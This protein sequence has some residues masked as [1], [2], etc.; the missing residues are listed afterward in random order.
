MFRVRG[1]NKVFSQYNITIIIV[2]L[3]I[4]FS[5]LSIITY[6]YFSDLSAHKKTEIKELTQQVKSINE[7]LVKNTK[8]LLSIQKFA[9]YF[10]KYPDDLVTKTPKLIQDGNHYYVQ[11]R[12]YDVIDHKD[13]VRNNI[14]GIGDIDSLDKSHMAEL[15][16]SN[17]LTPAFVATKQANEEAV[18]FYYVSKKRFVSIY[19]SINRNSW[20]Y[21]DILLAGK[22]TQKILQSGLDKQEVVW[23]SPYLGSAGSG[24]NT[25]LGIGVF[26]KAGMAGI[27]YVDISLARLQKQ[28]SPITKD[29]VGVLVL[30]SQNKVLIHHKSSNE[31][32]G[33]IEPWENVVPQSLSLLTKND[34]NHLSLYQERG[35][36]LVQKQTL[37]INGWSV[38][39]YQSLQDFRQ[40][41]LKHYSV[42]FLILFVGLTV[43]FA[44]IYWITHRTFVKPTKRFISHIEYCAQGDPG[45]IKPTADWLRW[46]Q[47]VENIFGQNRSL[48]QRLTDQNLLLDTRVNEKTQELQEKV[49]QHKRDYALLKSVMN[50]IPE[51][52][53]FNDIDG[54]IVG[55]NDT[56]G[57][58][59]EKSRDE[60]LGLKANEI[61]LNE[62]GTALTKL[63]T[64]KNV[65][66]GL[67][68]VVHTKNSTYDIYCTNIHSDT[69]IEVGT[70]DIIRDVTTQ[71][72]IQAALENTKNQAEFA[73]K[74]KSQFL[75]NMSHEIRT[76]I[77]AI[78]GMIT[79]LG[80]SNLTNNQRQHIDNAYGASKSL[81]Y[82][83]DQLLDLA[84]IESG[85][86]TLVKET[87]SLD[88]I[89]NKA[90]MLNIGQI[91]KKNLHIFVDISPKVPLLVNTDEMRLTQVLTNLL[92]NSVKFTQEGKITISVE[93]LRQSSKN[94]MIR[95]KI[96]DTG[97]GIALDKQSHLFEAFKQADESMTRQYGGSG[98]GLSICQQIVQL[99]DG[100]I[101]F[102]S[103]L[104]QGC[105]FTIEIPFKISAENETSTIP[106]TLYNYGINLPDALLEAIDTFGW[107]YLEIST[108]QDIK[109]SSFNDN[110]V[111]LAAEDKLLDILKSDTHKHIDLLC[112]CQ[113]KAYNNSVYEP[114][115]EQLTM[116]YIIQEQPIYRYMLSSI[117]Q[118]ILRLNK[119]EL[120]T[121]SQKNENLQGVKVLLVEDNLVNQLVAKE[122]LISMKAEVIIAENGQVALDLLEKNVIHI[123]LMDIQMPV[124]DGLTATKLIRQQKQFSDLPII[125]MTAHA[126]KEDRD[127][128][129][130]AGM[131][132]HM[133]KPV[134]YDTLLNTILKLTN[135]N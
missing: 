16:M 13:Y 39:K 9:N 55:F 74:A 37:P 91:N 35:D 63:S 46:F 44:L 131:N 118:S 18:W 53:I 22:H 104:D 128:S 77:N 3:F 130:A 47:V 58:F 12:H 135:E 84:K 90:I 24:L 94:A 81:L 69:G 45:K 1:E 112:I 67:Q 25:S 109:K 19:P 127:S 95:F 129:L 117:K 83:V 21:S 100:N 82:L 122:L 41:L 133:A 97:I 115:L 33:N 71:Y 43:F 134:E 52:I 75:A 56:F 40:P 42:T 59:I 68:K 85:E 10:L 121:I 89:I 72:A 98:L 76:P 80:R 7:A 123:I 38:V 103:E 79:L 27:L 99:L 124:M 57:D 125:A 6:Q 105:E 132:L 111:V 15:A 110:V 114:I 116:P 14:T 73:N 31:A 8:A 49:I 54:N 113:T 50:A 36:W 65:K 17:M 107:T 32:F 92:Q 2:F 51:Y 120:S 26:N 29:N 93:A 28:L 66:D 64:S 4:V 78:Q 60:V 126:R 87:T 108:L 62:L 61:I 5:T 70:I 23:S 20:Q 34:I 101:S 11:Y 88:S 119:T 86:M 48:L 30:D 106:L 102:K 96:K